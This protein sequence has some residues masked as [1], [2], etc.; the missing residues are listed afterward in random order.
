MENS[1]FLDNLSDIFL[2]IIEHSSA[3]GWFWPQSESW[4]EVSA[5]A[6]EFV[7]SSLSAGI[8]SIDDDY[9]FVH[10]LVLLYKRCV[11]TCSMLS[12]LFITVY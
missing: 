7:C 11:G 10:T 9:L 1:I 12:S 4:Q 3:L 2:D 5:A 6:T 8:P